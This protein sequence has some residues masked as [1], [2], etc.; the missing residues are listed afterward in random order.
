MG[1]HQGQQ[2]RMRCRFTARAAHCCLARHTFFAFNQLAPDLH[3]SSQ[4]QSIVNAHP[5]EESPYLL[6]RCV[7]YRVAHAGHVVLPGVSEGNGWIRIRSPAICIHK[8]GRKGVATCPLLKSNI[9]QQVIQSVHMH[10]M[11]RLNRPSQHHQ[12]HVT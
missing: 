12:P 8:C 3:S 5:I 4:S 1:G 6:Y 2:S 11:A 9:T 10:K 7:L